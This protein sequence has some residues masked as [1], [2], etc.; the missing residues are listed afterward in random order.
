MKALAAALSR[1]RLGSQLKVL[2]LGHADH[3]SSTDKGSLALLTAIME[4]PQHVAHLET[5]SLYAPRLSEECVMAL[6][7]GVMSCCPA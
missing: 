7:V 3:A 1:G 5:L 4:G 2:D 6:V